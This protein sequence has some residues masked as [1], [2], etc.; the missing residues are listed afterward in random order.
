MD[1]PTIWVISP[2]PNTRQLIGL[3]LSK[4]G[5]HT[6]EVPHDNLALAEGKPDAVIL[7]VDPPAELD[8]A[9]VQSIREHGKLHQVPLLLILADAPSNRRLARLQPARWVKKTPG[10]RRTA[11]H[12]T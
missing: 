12:S 7:D 3:N 1:G 6:L 2:H 8:G 9:A 11:D 5:Y 10:D 4:R